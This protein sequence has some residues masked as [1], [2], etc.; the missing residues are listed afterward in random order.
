MRFLFVASGRSTPST[1][2]RVEQFLPALREAGHRCDVAYSFPP[3]YD[4]FPWLGWR[5]SQRLKRIVRHRDAWLARRRKYDAILIEREVFDDDTFDLEAKFRQATSRLV[6]D[7]DDGV[8]LRHPGKF[9]AIAKMCDMAIAG[10]RCLEEYLEDLCQHVVLIPTCICMADYPE[11]RQPEPNAKPVIGW[12]G[13]TH[14]VVFLSVAAAALRKI[15][16]E[17]PF[18]LLIVATTDQRL[19]EIDLAGVDVEFRAWDPTREVAD[20]KE[21]DIGL[22]PLPDD[23][24]WMKYKCGLKLLQYLAVG[25]PGIASPIGVNVEI[26]QGEN[27]GRL[28][29]NDQQWEAALA[30]LLQDA[31]LRRNLGAAGR[32]LV[33]ERFS[34][35]S[36]W[37][38]L[39]QVLTGPTPGAASSR[40][41][42]R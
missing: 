7:V 33:Q 5:I 13:T 8:F 21:M 17:F 37:H 19:P 26:M 36:N 42:E 35:E 9:D 14:N 22:M 34:I 24:D 31:N 23:Q 27:V 40:S 4:Y 12:I 25:T 39:E 10:N 3:K 32:K 6:L 20:L 2:F 30:E 18:R 28:A 15:A 41:A 29:A 1:R 16:K 11:R 38:L